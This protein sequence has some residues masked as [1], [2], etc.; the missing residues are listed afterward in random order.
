MSAGGGRGGGRALTLL[1][2]SKVETVT[3]PIS[4]NV[5][6]V[7]TNYLQLKT[8]FHK[9]TQQQKQLNEKVWHLQTLNYIPIGEWTQVFKSLH[10]AQATSGS[11]LL[12]A[13][14]IDGPVWNVLRRFA[15][16]Q[17][18]NQQMQDNMQEHCYLFSYCGNLAGG[19]EATSSS[20]KL[21]RP[22][23]KMVAPKVTQEASK[24]PPMAAED[25]A[26]PGQ[27]GGLHG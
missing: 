22:L 10:Y 3:A 7:F 5:Y 23:D 4:F 27:D 17:I 24:G 18:R 6:R 16:S 15:N 8:I 21:G 9:G 12:A 25:G 20:W 26:P 19:Q 14:Q 11:C 1:S 2:W 13:L